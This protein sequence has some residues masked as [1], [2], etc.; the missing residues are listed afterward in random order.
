MSK[1]YPDMK[2]YTHINFETATIEL[3]E[4][5]VCASRKQLLAKENEY[6]RKVM[7]D[8]NCLN[9]QYPLPDDER[10][11]EVRVRNLNKMKQWYEENTERKKAYDKAYREKNAE[12]RRLQQKKYYQSKKSQENKDGRPSYDDDAVGKQT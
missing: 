4:D 9:S 3:V 2:V 6:I 10:K 8:P 5:F 7:Q 1:K 11:E 12:H